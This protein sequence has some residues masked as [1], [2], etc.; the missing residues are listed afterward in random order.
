[1][2]TD[3]CPCTLDIQCK[4]SLYC[5]IDKCEI[6]FGELVG[7]CSHNRP[8][9][10]CLLNNECDDN[11]TCT[12]NVC[13]VDVL[14][15]TGVCTFPSNGICGDG[16]SVDAFA[17]GSA[18]DAAGQPDMTQIDATEVDA[19][20][21]ADDASPDEDGSIIADG[22]SGDDGSMVGDDLAVADQIPIETVNFRG[23]GCQLHASPIS[24]DW[25]ILLSIG[26]MS[27]FRRRERS[28]QR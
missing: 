24:G 17:D 9:T 2:K 15:L 4:T 6:S 16:G 10:C 12:S 13:N 25:W 14:N 18:A 19:E 5:S 28:H 26:V 23:G 7:H 11:N 21:S 20:I 8:S 3:T 1:M 27:W 22:A